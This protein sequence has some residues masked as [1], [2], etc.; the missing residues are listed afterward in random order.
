MRKILTLKLRSTLATIITGHGRPVIT[1]GT[2][3]YC[4]WRLGSTRSARWLGTVAWLG[5]VRLCGSALRLGSAERSA[6]R[7]RSTRRLAY[8]HTHVG[9]CTW[10]W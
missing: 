7:A 6:L 8:T 5:A 3:D 2:A 10:A 1:T 9:T 4:A